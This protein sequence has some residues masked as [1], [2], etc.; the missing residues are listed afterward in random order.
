MYAAVF[1]CLFV[2]LCCNAVS[3]LCDCVFFVAVLVFVCVCVL[4]WMFYCCYD[5]FVVFCVV[6]EL[7]AAVFVCLFVLCVAVS[8]VIFSVLCFFYSR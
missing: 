6:F 8:V 1:V 3:L 5:L 4:C 2:C 7:Y